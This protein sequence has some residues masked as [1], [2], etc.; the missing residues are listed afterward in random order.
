MSR[1][2]ALKFI[3]SMYPTTHTPLDNANW[4]GLLNHSLEAPDNPGLAESLAEGWFR[5]ASN[6]TSVHNI[7]D[8][9]VTIQTYD[10]AFRVWGCGTGNNFVFQTEHVGYA[11]W[12]K[13]QWRTPTMLNCMKVSA[14][15][16]AWIWYTEAMQKRG[17]TYYPDWLSLTQIANRS[18]SGLL[19]H[20][21]ARQV[22]GGTTHTDPGPNFPYAELKAYIWAELDR[23]T[24]K[25]QSTGSGTKKYTVV[26]GDTLGAIANKFKVTVP[27]LVTWNRIANP[28]NIS[29]GQVLVVSDPTKEEDMALSDD[30]K[31][32]LSN[33]VDTKVRAAIN[34]LVPSIVNV[35]TLNHSAGL[36]DAQGNLLPE[37]VLGMMQDTYN[38]ATAIKSAMDGGSNEPPPPNG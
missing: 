19:T 7:A 9:G 12:S 24:G 26:S 3:P 20:N 18:R 1:N 11:A 2:P 30:D 33:M 38:A 15:A 22:W 31:T 17:I 37:N 36:K 16:Q 23:L 13:A 6:Q 29:I 35:Q 10:Y 4:V 5:T 34:A 14:K 8:R 28:D 21:D 25:N 27:Q 32:W